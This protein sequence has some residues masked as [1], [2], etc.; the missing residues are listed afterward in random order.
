MK[1]IRKKPA[2]LGLVKYYKKYYKLLLLTLLLSGIYTGLSVYATVLQGNLL[3]SFVNFSFAN[4]VKIALI[5]CIVMVV[6]EIITNQWSRTVL[7]L[8]SR[9]DFDLKQK[10]LASL[11][12]LKVS[13]FD[14][15]NSGMFVARINKDSSKL[16]ELFDDV[17]DDLSTV[18]LNVSFIVYS[19]FINIY[20]ALF[21][22]ANII[23]IY[24]FEIFKN[25]SYSKKHEKYKE[26]DDNIVGSYGEVVHGIRDIKNLDMKDGMM[27]KVNS[28]QKLAIT[29]FKEE[30]HTR[31]TWNRYRESVT[32][33]L[34]FLFV[35]LACYLI[36]ENKLTIGGFLILYVYKTNIL[37][38][39][40]AIANIKEKLTEGEISSKRV[41]EIIEE[42]GGLDKE[43]YGNQ[44][45]ESVN[46]R[47]EFKNVSFAYNENKL[48]E[49]MSFDIKPNQIV[50]FVGKSGEG[51]SS[52]INLI[53]KSYE[54]TSG[55]ILLDGVNLN[56]LDEDTI[57]DNI[58]VVSQHPYIF[59][60]SIEDNLKLIDEN[61]T[62]EEI[63][64][65]CKLADIHDFIQTLPDGYKT[66]IGENGITLSGGQRQRLAIARCLLKKSKIIL[67]D[68]ATSALDNESQDNIKKVIENIATNHTVIVVAHRLST[69]INSNEIFVLDNHKILQSGT[70]DEL[71]NTCNVYKNLYKANEK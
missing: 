14:K 16:S 53:N 10:M 24:F 15:L 35:V 54:V 23:I 9:M 63:F 32:H 57:R 21:L 51:K 40:R 30:T 36:V 47:I 46:G 3:D 50:A 62:N 22:F 64:S 55:E 34:N 38:F 39:I 56:I 19:F 17:T 12:N 13:N 69:I 61:A 48:F 71:L 25:K 68:E 31:R 7:K 43:K 42:G 6:V 2:L 59:N 58:S 26:L 44:H 41:F 70:H 18:L 45:L 67:L 60:L 28:E 66:I 1:N 4:S 11:M 49:N 5:M 29:A 27:T 65:A 37:Q 20:L 8:N 52:I 33:V